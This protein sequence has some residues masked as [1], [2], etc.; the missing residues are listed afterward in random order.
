MMYGSLNTVMKDRDKL[1]IFDMDG[2]L[3]DTKNVNYNAYNRAIKECGFPAEIDYDFYCDYCNGNSYK[4]FLPKIIPSIS[5]VQMD[6]IHK[7]KKQLYSEYLSYAKM[8]EKLFF[9]LKKIM[10]KYQI[11]LVTTA[12]KDNTIDLLQTFGV[13]GVF[14]FIITQEDVK[15]TKPDPEGFL[16][17]M[18]R[19][20][21]SPEDTLIFEDS[22]AGIEAA[23]MTKADYVI[24]NGYN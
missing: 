4:D 17:A 12:S 16:T 10:D 9:I 1:A 6:I 24:I 15:R 18:R 2:T 7:R 23:K 20:G 19:A 5:L 13:R 11:A 21:V 8:N 22:E 14:D 3:F